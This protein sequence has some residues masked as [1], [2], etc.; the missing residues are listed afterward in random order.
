MSKVKAVTV[1]DRWEEYCRIAYPDGMG[2]KQ[3]EH[4]RATFY[5]AFF[6][7]INTVGEITT[8]YKTHEE[9]GD[10]VTELLDECM[11]F[12]EAETVRRLVADGESPE[13]AALQTRAM[14]EM[15]N[16]E[17]CGAVN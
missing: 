1:S 13:M 8:Q 11:G 10:R 9:I 14:V 7:A 2:V 4:C 17:A 16:A 15:A 6:D 5:A 12:A 3:H